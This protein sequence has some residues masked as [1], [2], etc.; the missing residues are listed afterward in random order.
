MMDRLLEV[1]KVNSLE[2]LAAGIAHEMNT[3][4]QIITG[5]ADRLIDL[6]DLGD[7]VDDHLKKRLERI[8]ENGWRLAEIVNSLVAYTRTSTGHLEPCD[9]NMMA[10]ETVQFLLHT[11]KGG[12][13]IEILTELT[14][15]LPPIQCDRHKIMQVMM[16]LTKNAREAMSQGGQITI[17]T[18]YDEETQMFRITISDTGHGI[19]AEIRDRVFDP[20]FTTRQFGEGMGLGLSVVLGIVKSHGGKI[21]FDS[22]VGEGT[23]FRVQLPKCPPDTSLF[24]INHFDYDSQSSE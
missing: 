12:P 6:V 21:D 18:G 3:P 7:I 11:I 23:T 14:P 24:K 9:L 13:E 8:S 22:V 20:F 19:S 2:T 15:D 5:A 16:H 17:S 4:L 1:N 10:A